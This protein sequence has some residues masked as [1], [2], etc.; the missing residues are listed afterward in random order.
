[1]LKEEIRERKQRKLNLRI[2]R[3]EEAGEDVKGAEERKNRDLD[4]CDN[5][6]EALGMRMGNSA[7]DWEE[8]EERNQDPCWWASTKRG[9]E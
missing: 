4:S 2:D 7:G 6:F 3:V 1:M 5:I 9:Q 8:K